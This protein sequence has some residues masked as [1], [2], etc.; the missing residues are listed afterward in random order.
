[1]THQILRSTTL[2]T[3]FCS[4]GYKRRGSSINYVCTEGRGLDLGDFAYVRCVQ[5]ERGIENMLFLA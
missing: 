5:R 1:M 2:A 4:V 3:A